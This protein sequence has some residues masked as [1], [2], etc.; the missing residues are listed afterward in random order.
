M[1]MKHFDA[2]SLWAAPAYLPR[3]MADVLLIHCQIGV[4]GVW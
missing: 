3:S 1:Q 2:G 4:V